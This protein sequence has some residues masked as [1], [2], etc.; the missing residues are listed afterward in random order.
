MEILWNEGCKITAAW[1]RDRGIGAFVGVFSLAGGDPTPQTLAKSLYLH[2][3]RFLDADPL[4]APTINSFFLESLFQFPPL[5]NLN[6]W[7]FCGIERKYKVRVF[8]A[9]AKNNVEANLA[10]D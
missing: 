8:L 6:V 4:F 3:D 7:I 2:I 1:G 9:L 10:V 5:W